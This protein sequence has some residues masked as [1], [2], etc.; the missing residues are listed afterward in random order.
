MCLNDGR[1]TLDLDQHHFGCRYRDRGCRMHRNAQRAMVGIGIHRMH[2]RYLHHGQQ[3]EQN[4]THDG[5]NRQRSSLCA[6]FSAQK[7]LK[8]SQHTYPC[9]KNTQCLMS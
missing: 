6:A 3:C 7:C 2:M 4:Q 9:F 5:R 8:I 1:R